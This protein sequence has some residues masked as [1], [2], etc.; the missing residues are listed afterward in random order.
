MGDVRA[1]GMFSESH[2]SD[3][4][5]SKYA[6]IFFSVMGGFIR[7]TVKYGVVYCMTQLRISPCNVHYMKPSLRVFMIFTSAL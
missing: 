1:E 4:S 2:T 6:T 3:I 5:Q 7:V